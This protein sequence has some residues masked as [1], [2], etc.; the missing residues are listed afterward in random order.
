MAINGALADILDETVLALR[1][2]D[3]D[4]LDVLKQ[5]IVRLE[6]S[7]EKFEPDDA[8]LILSKRRLLEI[9]LQNC[10]V[11]LDVL[12]RLHARNMRKQWAQ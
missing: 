9:V 10:Q 2:L 3:S 6:E 1:D 5:Q 8:G 7:S 11:N 4:A 12:T